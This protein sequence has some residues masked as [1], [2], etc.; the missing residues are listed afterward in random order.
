MKNHWNGTRRAVVSTL[1]AGALL[2][3]AV[4]QDAPAPAETTQLP[5]TRVVVYKNGV[6]Y[7][8]H[9][10][11]VTGSQQFGL[12]VAAGDMDDLLQSLVLHDFGGGTI[13]AVRY[14]AE[15]PLSRTLASY[16]LNLAGNPDLANLLLQARGETVTLSGAESVTGT[17]LSVEQVTVP[18]EADRN[19]VLLASESGLRRMA[20]DEVR[21][22]YF[23]SERL[24]QELT[25]A[26]AAVARER[27]SDETTV[28]L[29]F[30]GEGERNVQVGY[31]REMPVWKS[32]YRLVVGQEGTAELQGWA[33]LDNPTGTDLENVQVTFVAGQPVSFITSLYEAVYVRRQR[34]APPVAQDDAAPAAFA[35]G[36]TAEME[37]A[38][39][40]PAFAAQARS[41]EDAAMDTLMDSGVEA[42]ASGVQTGVTFQYV[43]SEPVTVGRF[44]SAMIPI[45]M[46]EITAQ[47]LSVFDP[48]R[49]SPNPL[50]AVL[51]DNDTGLHLAA[52]T[53]TVFDSGAFSG[54]ALMQ[55]VLPDDTALLAFAADLAVDV[56]HHTSRRPEEVLSLRLQQGVMITEVRERYRSTYELL[57]DVGENR[58]VA[59]EHPRRSGFDL[60]VPAGPA[61]VTTP[62][63]YRFG[64]LLA[65]DSENGDVTG[66]SDF[67]VQLECNAG[68][69]CVLEVIEERVSLRRVALST[70]P[71]DSI[72]ILLENELLDAE[73]RIILEQ[74]LDLGR[75]ISGL[76]GELSALEMQRNAIF[77]E[78]ERIRANM[79]QLAQDSSL[80]QRYSAQLNE[81]ED[82]LERI[83]TERVRIEE[84]IRV[85]EVQREG[86]L[87]DF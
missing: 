37:A 49:G 22:V 27:G 77:E 69:E 46:E 8:E 6:A 54:T 68:G 61:P 28:R 53:V 60:T 13:Q 79:G 56:A 62:D 11:S 25:D 81:Q 33:I 7:F 59:I 20:L 18:D 43:V 57:A 63:T 16:S 4:A 32:S 74:L 23:E 47:N 80:Y 86:L 50:R 87:G 39:P 83:A 5:V 40:A 75:Q 82:E 70:L 21:E 24:R 72:V 36:V 1:A 26:L 58:L 48:T 14:A 73:A 29:Q 2:Q 42:Q 35:R 31:V 34:L 78:Q 30:S 64:V 85:L 38:P 66:D 71:T 65:A 9:A 3:A 84:E 76:S 10:G 67:P 41:F 52:G 19:Y 12:P 55:D 17:V 15:D 44:E 45:L 51:V